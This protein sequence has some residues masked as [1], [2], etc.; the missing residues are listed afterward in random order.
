MERARILE[1]TQ[2]EPFYKVRVE[3]LRPFEPMTKELEAL[4]RAALTYFESYVRLGKKVPA[5]I[6]SSIQAVQDR[7]TC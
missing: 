1:Y 2:A 5:E 4:M 3:D 7:Q 6:L